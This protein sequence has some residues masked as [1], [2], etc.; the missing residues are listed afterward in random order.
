V[1]IARRPEDRLRQF[2]VDA[3]HELRAP[4]TSIVAAIAEEHQGA[5]RVANAPAVAPSSPSSC[6]SRPVS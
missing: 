2:L 1:P 4:L 5:A 3:S 6:P